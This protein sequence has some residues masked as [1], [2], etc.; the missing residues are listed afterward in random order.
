MKLSFVIPA[1]N[2]EN[3][4]GDCLVSVRE[5]IR[6][7]KVEAEIIMV[8]NASTD[9]TSQVAAGFPDVRIVEEP[10]K[11]LSR[12]R[13]AGYLA[14][15]GELIANLDADTVLPSG[16]IETVLREFDNDPKLAALSGP[17]IFRDAPLATRFWATVFSYLA[18]LVSMLYLYVFHRGAVL[19]GGNFV[20]RKTA[21]D[22]AGGFDPQFSFY[23]EDSGA[24]R[25]LS[26]F[27]KVIYTLKLPIYASD[28]RLR[29]EGPLRLGV[30]Y[31][32]NYLWVT[33]WNRPFSLAAKD[34]RFS[35][36]DRS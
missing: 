4:L 6:E 31:I 14:A 5:R 15:R 17:H 28:R 32:M 9:R 35:G 16:W 3:Y 19:Q 22:K 34:I 13:H 12:A 23:G 26:Q 18:C 36:R 1:H 20:V 33:F 24:A 21:L 27:G 25:L 8:N 11:G 10:V 7:V 30:R 2:E 29:A